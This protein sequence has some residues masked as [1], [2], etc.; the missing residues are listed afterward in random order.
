[1]YI[2][3]VH[4]FYSF[5]CLFYVVEHLKTSDSVVQTLNLYNENIFIA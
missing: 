4:Y 5:V 1:M 3:I 2:L